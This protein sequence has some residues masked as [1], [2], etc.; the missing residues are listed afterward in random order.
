MV[1]FGD[2]SPMTL[3]FHA[4]EKPG[5]H[6]M[7][8]AARSIVWMVIYLLFI[9]LPLFAL[10]IGS[11]PPARGFWTE[12]SAALG[13]SG[14]AIMGLQFGLTARFRF[15]TGPWGE[16]VIYHFHRRISLFAVAL[17]VVHP[18][19][20]F[21]VHPELLAFPQYGEVSWGAVF[22]FLS[23][24]SL[25]T[26]VVTA[27]WRAKLRI[28]YELWHITHV[29]LA[30][31]A[32]TG[33]L[34][35]MVGWGFYLAD[36]WKRSLWI[37]LTIF[38]IALVFYVRVV[39][40]LFILRRPY[41]VQEVRRERGD[42]TTLV[43][44]PDGHPGFRFRPG[45]FGWLTVWGSPFKITAH[46]FSF[47][48]SAATSDGHVEISIRNL[49]DFT[50]EINKVPV[51]QRVYLDGPYG[52]FTIGN[53]ADMH[54]LIAGGVGITP[55]MSMIRTL[56]DV[57]DKRAVVLLYGSKDWDSITFREELEKLKARLDLTVVHVLS[58]PPVGWTGERG[59]MTAEVLMRHLPK[60]CADHEYFICG[61][62]VMMDAIERGLGEL[63]V[64][65][66]KYHSERYSFV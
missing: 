8:Y 4:S 2:R 12:F 33:G 24:F 17:V 41:R 62:A 9:F 59:F 50:R 37:A 66:S 31:I 6:S 30:I 26:L 58:E 29:T 53:P 28:P 49:G 16:D 21:S 22:A 44:R 18:L 39:K 48:S 57:G 65:M 3:L 14:L 47:S 20:M 46:P 25:L 11:L 54:V 63:G 35:H 60:P 10:L 23:V 56:A 61:P 7:T 36:P 13:Y 64:P 15:V 19:I 51:G 55:M 27:L 1:R 43:M 5:T 42:T 38:W 32:V 45:Q 52:A 34:L 40:P